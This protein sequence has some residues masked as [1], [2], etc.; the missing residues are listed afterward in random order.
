MA[1]I[2]T[3]NGGVYQW[4]PKELAARKKLASC[5]DHDVLSAAVSPD[6][7]LDRDYF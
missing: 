3:T 6:G 4:H 7:K 1:A 2:L 5:D